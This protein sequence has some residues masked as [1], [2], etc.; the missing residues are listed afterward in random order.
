MIDIMNQNLTTESAGK[1]RKVNRKRFKK[2]KKDRFYPA[3]SG[4]LRGKN[5]IN[6][7]IKENKS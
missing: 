3:F 7:T 1:C 6:Q 2:N 4:T 5:L